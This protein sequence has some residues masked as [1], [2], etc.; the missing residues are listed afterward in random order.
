[1][2]RSPILFPTHPVIANLPPFT[3]EVG[4]TAITALIALLL[5]NTPLTNQPLATAIV[6]PAS[7]SS[8]CWTTFKPV[9]D[10]SCT[11]VNGGTAEV[12]WHTRPALPIAALA[13]ATVV[14]GET[15]AFG[16]GL[17]SSC[18]SVA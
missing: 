18:I 15:R 12:L 2:T 5:A 16:F 9:A 4:A 3:I 17:A 8:A 10:F 1:M 7:I 6:V 11:A 13:F 14:V